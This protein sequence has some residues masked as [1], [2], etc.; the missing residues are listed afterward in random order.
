MAHLTQLWN[1]KLKAVRRPGVDPALVQKQWIVKWDDP[2]FGQGEKVHEESFAQ[3]NEAM[4]YAIGIGLKYDLR[5]RNG[6]FH[7][8]DTNQSRI[9]SGYSPLPEISAIPAVWPAV[10][11]YGHMPHDIMEEDV[12]LY[13]VKHGITDRPEH[14]LPPEKRKEQINHN[15][16]ENRTGQGPLSLDEMLTKRQR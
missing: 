3:Y 9:K 14:S 4:D 5:K 16:V 1:S 15:R 10:T 12:A 7:Q 6:K 11:C 2:N 13:C 8:L